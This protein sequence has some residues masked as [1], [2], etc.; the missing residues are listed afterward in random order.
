MSGRTSLLT[1]GRRATVTR[2]STSQANGTNNGA[3]SRTAVTTTQAPSEGAISTT[4]YAR[5]CKALIALYADLSDL[6]ANAFFELP[7][8]TVIGAQSGWSISLALVIRVHVLTAGKSSLV[9]AVS[10]VRLLD[11]AHPLLTTT[12]SP[13]L[14]RVG[15]VPGKLSTWRLLV[16]NT[17]TR[18]PMECNM[19]S[20]AT[21]WSCKIALRRD[22]HPDGTPF[23]NGGQTTPFGTTITDRSQVELWLRRAQAAIL[24]PNIRHEA[25]YTKTESELIAAF[26][27]D[28]DG[29]EFSKNAVVVYVNDPQITDLRFVDLPG[30]IQNH[31]RHPELVQVVEDL[32]SS[33][34]KGQNTLILVTLPMTDDLENQ[35][36]ARLA[37]EA[38]PDG[39]RT[40]GVLTKPD[41]V[42]EGELGRRAGWKDVLEGRKN[43]LTHGY[44][45]IRLPDDK[46]RRDGTSR[47]TL[48]RRGLQLYDFVTDHMRFG[49]DNLTK[50]LSTLLVDRIESN[51]PI[52]RQKL[53]ALLKECQDHLD[54]LPP[55]PPSNETTAEVTLL[56][57]TFCNEFAAAVVGARDEILAQDCRRHYRQFSIAIRDTCP[58]FRPFTDRQHGWDS[59]QFPRREPQD[60]DLPRLEL[61]TDADLNA[62]AAS[63][64]TGTPRSL[65]P[66]PP[67]HA[68]DESRPD[69]TLVDV[70]TVIRNSVSWQLP[71][72]VPFAATKEIVKKSTRTWRAPSLACF[73]A[74]V[75]VAQ[76]FLD[77]LATKH[78]S[79]FSELENTIR[80]LTNA[81]I[82]AYKTSALETL[83][84]V[85][86]IEADPL[87]T[88]NENL[89]TTER[90]KWRAHYIARHSA[91]YPFHS[92]HHEIA[93]YANEFTMM[94]QVRAYW[95]I[96]YQRFIDYIPLIIEHEFTHL[97]AQNLQRALFAELLA[98]DAPGEVGKRM[99]ALLA[100]NPTISD[101]RRKLKDK[102][103]RLNEMQQRLE[104]L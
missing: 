19:S 100:E 84:K 101:E 49:V 3:S 83:D 17:M 85:L 50:F 52:L 88:H 44:F 9:E 39:Q 57:S 76:K 38:D 93:E 91:A 13:F 42:G 51:L 32:V 40:I 22:Y 34:I 65:S 53:A 69:L 24:N 59:D 74:I 95:Q 1:F 86:K 61:A 66:M 63:I 11:I 6:G 46:E 7:N 33:R 45:C 71:G 97:L 27:A 81:E 4:E 98:E 68:F 15:P 102:M 94:G 58:H 10:G 21:E 25:F 77:T 8:I 89:F 41:A 55:P 26:D 23:E 14:A 62:D 18:C 31:E 20:N 29:L 92:P 67:P 36:S 79:Q 12:R 43:Q 5:R 54:A 80:M 56:V 35:S 28:S 47:D 48:E 87:F 72:N 73:E 75:G 64:G 96:A 2:S 104:A 90:E 78:F 37:R 103:G 70:R 99:K 60:Y 30:L 82:A 16:A